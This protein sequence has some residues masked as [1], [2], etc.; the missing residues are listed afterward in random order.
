VIKIKRERGSDNIQKKKF[1]GFIYLAT[2]QINKKVYVGQ[3]IRKIEEEWAE[4][5]SH[6]IALRKKREEDPNIVIKCR[7]IYNAIAKYQENVWDLKLLDIAY[8][9]SELD[10]K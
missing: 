2:N 7:Y 5:Y 6:G 4:I 3:T 10:C 9:K 8:S 1:Y